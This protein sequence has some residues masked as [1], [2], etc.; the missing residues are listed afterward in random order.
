M[1]CL[2]QAKPVSKSHYFVYRV[3]VRAREHVLMT[4]KSCEVRMRNAILGNNFKKMFQQEST[5]NTRGGCFG[6][7]SH[8]LMQD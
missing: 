3:Y 4:R 1:I 7:L 6:N 5:G 2:S 8:T